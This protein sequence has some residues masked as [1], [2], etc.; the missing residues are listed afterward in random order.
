[1]KL[2]K[3]I[4]TRI[5]TAVEVSSLPLYRIAEHCDITYQTLRNWLRNGEK[6]K[7]QLEEGK[8][9]KSDLNTKQKRELDLFVRFEVVRSNSDYD[10]RKRTRA[11]AEKKDDIHALVKKLRSLHKVYR[12]VDY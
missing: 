1:M 8:I 2:K 10:Q 7:Q 3:N 5:V 12:E 4:I 11:S 9:R 6:Y